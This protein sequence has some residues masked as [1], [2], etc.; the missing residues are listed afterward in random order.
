M[1]GKLIVVLDAEDIRRAVKKALKE[2]DDLASF[3]MVEVISE[4]KARMKLVV[5]GLDIRYDLEE[6]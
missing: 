2:F 6:L 3:V 4:H 5:P 1:A